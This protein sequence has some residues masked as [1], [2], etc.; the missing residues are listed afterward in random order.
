MPQ[1]APLGGDMK[2]DVLV[3]GG[4]LAGIL[5]AYRLSQAGVDCVLV[6]QGE[7]CGG[8]TGNTTAKITVQHG[9]TYHKLLRQFGA[10]K[11]RLYLE[12]NRDALERYRSL[13]RSIDCDFEERDS[14]VYALNDRRKLERELAA[15]REL[16]CEADFETDLSLPLQTA[17]AVRIPR[18]AQFH[19]LKFAAGIS[20]GLNIFTQ[21]KVLELAPGKAVTDRGII[22]AKK[23]HYSH[24][25]SHA[26][27]ARRLFFKAVPAPLLRFGSEG[28]CGSAGHVCG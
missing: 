28:R 6:E 24:P 17:G 21:T 5:C 19:P 9:L 18:Q 3:I 4:G 20:R 8:I 7:L 15:L 2:T 23:N 27:Q 22:S 14:F 1:F 13:S 26:Q 12:A 11:A 10:A 16:R 25:F